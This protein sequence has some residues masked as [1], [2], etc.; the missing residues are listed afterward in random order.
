MNKT[1]LR[2]VTGQYEYV[3]IT[4]DRIL[5]PEEV[6]DL[7]R[8]YRNA[9]DKGMAEAHK[10][11][12]KVRNREPIPVDEFANVADH[13]G[14][15]PYNKTINDV[16]KEMNRAEYAQKKNNKLKDNYLAETEI[17]VSQELENND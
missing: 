4:V 17:Q 3:E 5:T 7:T 14:Y 11:A 1:L 16:K 15:M 10:V 6:M 9:G 2:I 12:N 8:K 13:S